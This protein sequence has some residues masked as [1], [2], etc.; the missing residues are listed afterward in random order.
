MKATVCFI[1]SRMVYLEIVLM[2]RVCAVY[3]FKYDVLNV[4][5]CIELINGMASDVML[6][7]MFIF[8]QFNLLNKAKCISF[9]TH[10]LR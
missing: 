6:N 2:I 7:D 4:L 8:V 9:H 10:L 5:N 3:V 1:R